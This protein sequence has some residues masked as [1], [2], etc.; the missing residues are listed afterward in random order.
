MGLHSPSDSTLETDTPMGSRHDVV[1]VGPGTETINRTIPPESN[2]HGEGR[3]RCAGRRNEAMSTDKGWKPGLLDFSQTPETGHGLREI[4]LLHQEVLEEKTGFAGGLFN[5][6]RSFVAE[7]PDLMVHGSMS[8]LLPDR[9]GQAM[10]GHVVCQKNQ[11]GRDGKDD[12]K[13][14]RN[15]MFNLRIF[16]QSP[17]PHS[18]PAFSC[19]RGSVTPDDRGLS[20][21]FA[22]P[23]RR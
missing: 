18:S 15:G 19:F 6:R 13:Q 2:P 20:T 8:G 21:F 1:T 3:W 11:M 17:F 10:A 16:S 5:R 9:S 22:T 12:Q 7:I 4:R 23:K 14:H